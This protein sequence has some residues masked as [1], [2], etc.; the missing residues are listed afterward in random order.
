MR[1]PYENYIK[2]LIAARKPTDT[3]IGDLRSLELKADPNSIDILRDQLYLEQPDYFD[4]YNEPVDIDWLEHH[5]IDRM[6]G[7]MYDQAVRRPV[8]PAEGALKIL[9]DGQIYRIVTAM[10]FAGFDDTDIE[11]IIQG[12]L[13]VAYTL[14]DFQEFLNYFFNIDRWTKKDK[15][16]YLATVRQTDLKRAYKEA[17]KGD[18]NKLLWRLKLSPKIEFDEMLR[19]IGHDSFYKFKDLIETQP[20]LALKFAGVVEKITGRMEKIIEERRSDQATTEALSFIFEEDEKDDVKTYAD[21]KKEEEG[22]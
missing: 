19:E 6:F 12:K 22:N 1:L 11:L 5:N 21:L 17:L 10:A 8:E 14:E 20:D 15:E 16:M 9:E 4:D 7:Y 18:K 3:V 2:V 13:D